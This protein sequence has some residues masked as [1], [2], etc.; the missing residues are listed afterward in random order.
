M[1]QHQAISLCHIELILAIIFFIAWPHV[2]LH[3]KMAGPFTGLGLISSDPSYA[4]IYLDHLHWLYLLERDIASRI[5]A[6]I[7]GLIATAL[8]GYDASLL[9]RCDTKTQQHH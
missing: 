8:F 9:A 5:I 2:A 1:P 3:T 7:L 4:I 6:G